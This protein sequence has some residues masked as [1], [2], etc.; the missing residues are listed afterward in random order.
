MV[1][2]MHRGR[3]GGAPWMHGGAD[4]GHGSALTGAWPPATPVRQSSL[5]GRKTERGVRGTRLRSHRS[6]GGAVELGDSGAE[7]GGGGAR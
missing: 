7:R 1:N 2:P 3:S 6:S 5:V 4:R